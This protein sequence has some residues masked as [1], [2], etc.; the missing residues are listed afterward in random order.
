MNFTKLIEAC[1][2]GDLEEVEKNFSL[3]YANRL[4]DSIYGEH[5]PFMTAVLDDQYSIIKYLLDKV[6]SYQDYI[7]QKEELAYYYNLRRAYF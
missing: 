5:T 6:L 7:Y 3:K 2:N 1:K 4:Y